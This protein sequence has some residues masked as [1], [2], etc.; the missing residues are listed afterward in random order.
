MNTPGERAFLLD[1]PQPQR[2]VMLLFGEGV[3]LGAVLFV[4]VTRPHSIL[5]LLVLL[6][7]ARVFMRSARRHTRAIFAA[8][9]RPDRKAH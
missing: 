5:A 3:M 9:E 7:V 2:A 8:M 6:V 1:V 4:V